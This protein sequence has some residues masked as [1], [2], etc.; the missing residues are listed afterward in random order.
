MTVC[1]CVRVSVYAYMYMSVCVCVCVCMCMYMYNVICWY[2]PS[3]HA[4]HRQ[5]ARYI[6]GVGHHVLLSLGMKEG[7]HTNKKKLSDSNW[8]VFDHASHAP[9][10]LLLYVCTCVCT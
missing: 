4:L 5:I 10:L 6:E 2:L 1:V 3:N 7:Q 8:G 9:H